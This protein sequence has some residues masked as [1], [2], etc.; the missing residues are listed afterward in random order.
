LTFNACF[1]GIPCYDD[2]QCILTNETAAYKQAVNGEKPLNFWFSSRDRYP[3]LF[4]L[5][6][7]YLSVPGI[8]VDAERSVSR[9]T[10]VNAPQR[11]NFTDVNLALHVRMVFNSTS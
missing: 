7:R 2:K 5:A 9:Y 1:D 11:K 3:H 10:L 8:S 4:E 6:I